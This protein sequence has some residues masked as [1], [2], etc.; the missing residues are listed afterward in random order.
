[1]DRDYPG[2]V[3]LVGARG[4]ECGIA[5]VGGYGQGLNCEPRALVG[6]EDT[7]W[8]KIFVGGW[9]KVLP[10]RLRVPPRDQSR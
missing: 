10:S 6:A 8:Q 1:M 5:C 9:T 2:G 3:D 4:D 7:T